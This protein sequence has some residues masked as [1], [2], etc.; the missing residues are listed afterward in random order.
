MY[1][2]FYKLRQTPFRRMRFSKPDGL[3]PWRIT[4][5]LAL[6]VASMILFRSACATALGM[7]IS[8]NTAKLGYALGITY[9]DVD[10]P[11]KPT[12]GK[13]ATVPLTLIHTD[14]LSKDI[15]YWSEVFYYNA[16]L[17]AD[18]N[19]IGEDV[20]HYG[21]RISL[22][23]SLPLFRDWAPWFGIGIG[24]SQASYTTRYTADAD[25]FL[26]AVYPDR[27]QTSVALLLN[28]VNEW[29]LGQNWDIA[30]KL[31]AALPVTGDIR[32][33]SALISF[34]YRY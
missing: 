22:Q 24:V 9:V 34:L 18:V 26:L 16:T 29:P 6:S 2:S 20:E 1:E 12:T 31:E 32:E 8:E 27:K 11:V 19:R 10:D 13:W 28:V 21:L 33:Y 25:G 5:C 23:K 14:W 3:S 15:R 17:D 7:P 30:A 4:L